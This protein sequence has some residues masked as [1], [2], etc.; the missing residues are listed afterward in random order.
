MYYKDRDWLY[1]KYV[2]ERVPTAEIARMCDRC[3]GTII[4]W[5]HRH[6]ILMQRQR[7]IDLTGQKFG[8]LLVV[9][10]A[11]VDK[12]GNTLWKCICGCG[13]T[14]IFATSRLRIGS[15]THCGC[16]HGNK[17]PPGESNFRAALRSYRNHAKDRNIEWALTRASARA[18]ME[19]NCHYCG[20]PPANVY[21]NVDSG[22]EFF[23]NG[24][25]RV[26]SSAG[27]VEGNVVPC[28]K[29]CNVAKSDHALDK[30][31]EWVRAAYANME[32]W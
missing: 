16:S 23:Y 6:G 29:M 25:D 14:R 32:R 17:L 2:V 4:S 22:A 10:L 21:R 26:D 28:C 20:S 5:L 13:Q 1:T 12:R 15:A 3:Q 30:F 9:E 24:I 27:Y 11:G 7:M 19:M 8:K 31:K 18:I